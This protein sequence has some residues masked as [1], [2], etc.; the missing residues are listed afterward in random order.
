MQLPHLAHVGLALLASAARWGGGL[1]GTRGGARPVQPLELYDIEG[2]PYCRRV[3][4]ALTEL[5]LPVMIFPCPKGGVRFRP[6][7]EALGRKAQFPLLVDPNTGAQLYESRDIVRYLSEHYGDGAV[8][9]IQ[10]LGPVDL[11]TSAQA[12]A[13]RAGKGVRARPSRA[14]EAPLEL[15][16]FEASPFCR[17]VRE[18]LCELE[19]PYLLHNVGKRSPSR[20]AFIARS[21]RMMVPYLADPNTQQEMFESADILEYLDGHYGR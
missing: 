5:D 18:R 3:R 16:S 21:G 10:R 11:A 12:S 2:C 19:L 7:A 20:A 4:E 9:L 13:F 1:Y 8:P 14:P 17:V 6:K 15:Y